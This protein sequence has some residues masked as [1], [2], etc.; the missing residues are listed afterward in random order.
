MPLSPARQDAL[1]EA[2]VTILDALVRVFIDAGASPIVDK[3]ATQ[4]AAQVRG[5]AGLESDARTASPFLTQRE[6]AAYTG[7]SVSSLRRARQLGLP[8]AVVGGLVVF[9]RTVLDA[10]ARTFGGDLFVATGTRPIA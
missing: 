5:A 10:P 4:V 2:V 9:E 8:H 7:R 1:T 3:I 6:A